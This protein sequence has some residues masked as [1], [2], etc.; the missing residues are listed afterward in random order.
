MT[1]RPNNNFPIKKLEIIK[2]AL[3]L[4]IENGY[5]QTKISTIMKSAQLSKGGMYHYFDSKE[6]IL[7]AVIE[8]AFSEKLVGFENKFDAASD[9]FKKMEIFL[10][11]EIITYSEFATKFSTLTKNQKN[12]LVQY[13]VKEFNTLFAIPYLLSIINFG[14]QEG[15][16]HTDF[17]EETARVLFF[18]GDMLFNEIAA[19]KKSIHQEKEQLIS[20]KIDAF[21]DLI[22]KTLKI[23]E[24]DTQKFKQIVTKEAL[25][26]E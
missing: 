2:I 26:N 4:F 16:F 17:P 14:V 7:D 3:D 11:S 25:K 1:M 18:A 19:L 13:R 5:E 21:V 15:V 12:T 8:Y 20:R 23:N 10:D 24:S 9:T 6:A 22:K